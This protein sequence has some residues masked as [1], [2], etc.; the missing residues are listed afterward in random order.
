MQL[1]H[2]A[3]RT[4]QQYPDR[5]ATTHLCREYSWSQH[6]ARVACL[7]GAIQSLGLESGGRVSLLALN[8]D[9]YLETYSAVAWADG[10]IVPMNTRWS[11]AENLYSIEDSAPGI[12][13]VDDHFLDHARQVLEQTTQIQSVIYMGDGEIP[14]G[15][16]RYE[17][18]IADASPVAMGKCVPRAISAI[19]ST[20]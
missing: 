2:L 4:A 17:Q 15:M 7:A 8:S 3:Q 9:R 5:L 6:V 18:L 20:F 14:P 10:V 12:L 16:L 19:T 11:V 13:M 1:A